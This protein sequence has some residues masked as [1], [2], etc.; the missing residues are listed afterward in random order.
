MRLLSSGAKPR[1]AYIATMV[2]ASVGTESTLA[3]Q[4]TPANHLA[5]ASF[6]C[7][8]TSPLF[9][10]LS[11]SPTMRYEARPPVPDSIGIP[12]AMRSSKAPTVKADLPAYE[13]PV[14]PRPVGSMMLF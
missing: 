11:L 13:Q 7:S 6:N 4:N 8:G 1:G 3:E 12:S 5:Q 2:C 14:V 9:G 10:A